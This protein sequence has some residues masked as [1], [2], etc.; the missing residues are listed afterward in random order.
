MGAHI[1]EQ[2]L[3][4][5]ESIGLG[6]GLAWAGKAED[7]AGAP[8]VVALDRHRACEHD[9]QRL[10]ERAG[11]EDELIFAIALLMHAERLC[12]LFQP[13]GVDALEERDI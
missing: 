9:A 7:R 1:D 11:L 3:L 13:R 5:Q 12:H 8:D 6:E 4:R 10:R 2:R